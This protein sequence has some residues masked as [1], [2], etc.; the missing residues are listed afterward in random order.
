[1]RYKK[2]MFSMLL[3]IFHLIKNAISTV[4]QYNMSNFEFV[5][6]NIGMLQ[7]IKRNREIKSSPN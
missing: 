6:A 2:A 1:M 4:V 7:N 3:S 5:D